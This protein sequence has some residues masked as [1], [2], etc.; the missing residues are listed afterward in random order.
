MRKCWAFIKRDFAIMRSYRTASAIQ[1][2]SSVI[3]VPILYFVGNGLPEIAQASAFA[4]YGGDYF[5]FLLIGM[6]L[7]GYFSVSLQT[8]NR[9]IRDSQLMGTLEIVLQSP[10]SMVELLFYSS[11]WIYLVTTIRFAIYLGV[12]ALFG[13]DLGRGNV[14][15]ALAVMA[16]S[17][18]AFASFGIASAALVLIIKREQAMTTALASGSLLL[19]GVMYPL[20]ALPDWIRPVSAALPITHAVEGMRRALF[21]GSGLWELAPQLTLLAL[22]AFVLL[23][24]SLALFWLAVRHTKAAGTL[25]QY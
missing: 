4:P 14:L 10:T 15:S 17:V 16:V 6:G 25:S 19:G 21:Q 5:A 8:F 7:L 9:S 2:V 24:F 12:G 23:P 18:P 13:L 22:F 3:W 1:L 11:A 20:E